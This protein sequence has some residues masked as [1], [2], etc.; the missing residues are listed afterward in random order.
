M[1]D[2]AARRSKLL[3]CCS[4][5]R[6]QIGIATDRSASRF[7]VRSAP[8]RLIWQESFFPAC[9]GVLCSTPVHTFQTEAIGHYGFDSKDEK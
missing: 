5:A 7:T 6:L 4:L 3:N 1:S 8:S 9:S 2:F